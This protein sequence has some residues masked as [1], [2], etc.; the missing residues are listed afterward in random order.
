MCADEPGWLGI[1]YVTA[2]LGVVCSCSSRSSSQAFGA[3]RLA[4]RRRR[5]D[6]PGSRSAT[7]LVLVVLAALPGRPLGDDRQARLARLLRLDEG[8]RGRN[9]AGLGVRIS[10]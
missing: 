8:R 9:L 2:E 4:K 1:G 7:V 5:L 3:R 10:P 6:D